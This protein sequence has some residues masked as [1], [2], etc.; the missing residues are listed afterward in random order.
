[1]SA[2]AAGVSILS[3]MPSWKAATLTRWVQVDMAK[4]RRTTML[5]E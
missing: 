2:K 1:M 5:G 4:P 3:V